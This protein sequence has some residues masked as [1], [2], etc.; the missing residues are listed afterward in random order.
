LTD[1]WTHYNIHC[2]NF[3]IWFLFQNKSSKTSTFFLLELLI[4]AL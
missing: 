2:F 1:H 4:L 3:C